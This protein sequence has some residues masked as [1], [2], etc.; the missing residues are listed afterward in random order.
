MDL[1]STVLENNIIFSACSETKFP[2][3]Q[4]AKAFLVCSEASAF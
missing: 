3:H 4:K 2:A 1:V